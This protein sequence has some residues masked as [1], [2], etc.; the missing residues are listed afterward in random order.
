MMAIGK[1]EKVKV[2]SEEVIS[3]G[4]TG[5]F[6]HCVRI[7]FYLLKNKKHPRVRML[8][9]SGGGRGIRS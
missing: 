6:F 7:P 8:S 4:N 1:K 2:K 3:K 5:L 9:V